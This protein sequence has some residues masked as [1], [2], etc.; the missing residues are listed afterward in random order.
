[1]A[2]IPKQV[3]EEPLH[4]LNRMRVGK[5]RDSYEIP[6]H[7]DLLLI[8][9]TDRIRIFGFVLAAQVP[10]KGYVLNALNIFWRQYLRDELGEPFRYGDLVACGRGIDGFLPQHLHNNPDLQRRATVVKKLDMIPVKAIVRG[11]LTGG[12]WDAYQRTQPH[13]VCGHVLPDGL[14][15][16]SRLPTPLFTPTTKTEVGHDEHIDVEE[17][18]KRHFPVEEMAV[19]LYS[20]ASRH[21]LTRGIIIADTKFEFGSRNGV[22]C[23]PGDE[24]LTPDSSRFWDEKEYATAQANRASPLSHDKQFVREWGKGL[25]IHKLDPRNPE[26]E[27]RVHSYLLPRE[28]IEHTT[29]IYLDMCQRLTEYSLEKFHEE[30]L[31]TEPFLR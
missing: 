31:G 19:R 4:G 16:G 21:A 25:G 29:A 23:I 26:H 7:P 27:A 6:E 24:E 8:V 13:V 14:H 12:G 18:R 22:P 10:N 30:F 11:Y 17:V 15:D 2:T 9:T 3:L 28:V 5:V 20:V 1:M